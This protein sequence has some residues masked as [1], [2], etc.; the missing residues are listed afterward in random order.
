MRIS[1]LVRGDY[2]GIVNVPEGLQYKLHEHR[3]ELPVG[4]APHNA[5]LLWVVE[6]FAPG[7]GV[8]SVV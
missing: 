1:Y 4:V 3:L 6:V 2:D 8:K 7:S 5:L